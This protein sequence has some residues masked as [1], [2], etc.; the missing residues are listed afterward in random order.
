M[1]LKEWKPRKAISKAF[2]NVK[3]NTTA[4]KGFKTCQ[5]QLRDRINDTESDTFHKNLIIDF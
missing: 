4:I 2:L 5:M 3:P 1:E